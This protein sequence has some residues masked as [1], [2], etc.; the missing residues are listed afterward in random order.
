M[1]A[2]AIFVS[3]MNAHNHTHNMKRAPRVFISY[4]WDNEEHR[5][6]VLALADRLV[7]DG[8]DVLLDRYEM[9]AGRNLFAFIEHAITTS[10]YIIVVLTPEYKR[11]SEARNATAG[12]EY[13]IIS[14]GMYHNIAQQERVIPVLRSGN[15]ADSIPYFMQQFIYSD[16]SGSESIEAG[17]EALLRALHNAPE[18]LKPEIGQMPEL[19]A[20][21]VKREGLYVPPA[22]VIPQPKRTRWTLIFL[23]AAAA[24]LFSMAAVLSDGK[25]NEKRSSSLDTIVSH[26]TDTVVKPPPPENHHKS[27]FHETLASSDTRPDLSQYKVYPASE[28]KIRI[29]RDG[30]YGFVDTKGYALDGSRTIELKYDIAGDFHEG[31]AWVRENNLY[32]YIDGNGRKKIVCAYSDANDFNGG[33]AEVKKDGEWFY[34]DTAGNKVE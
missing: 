28:R 10:D 6:W 23:I 17:Y 13:S 25:E 22:T 27:E 18:Y 15:P 12:A 20:R 19:T 2:D 11:K 29:A 7:R 1:P 21:D 30:K 34:I 33:R 14:L 5:L 24:V 16:L 32:G 9:K 3:I 8:I 26:P 4:S 31:L